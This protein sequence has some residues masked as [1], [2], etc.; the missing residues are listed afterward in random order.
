MIS[1]SRRAVLPRNFRAN[2]P[3][4]SVLTYALLTNSGSSANL[5]A[6]TALTSPLLGDRRLKPGDEVITVAA[7]FPT[8]VN[9]IILNNLIPVFVDVDIPTYNIQVNQIEKALSL[10]TKAIFIAHTLGNPF[11][12]DEVLGIAQK[13]ELFLIEDCCDALGSTYKRL[14][15]CGPPIRLSVLS[16][17]SPLSASTLPII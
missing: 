3:P 7:G 13:H 15:D 16:A 4:K 2:W 11:N 10:K 17:T 14:D 1:G 5:L 12:L 6:L 8:T 9:P